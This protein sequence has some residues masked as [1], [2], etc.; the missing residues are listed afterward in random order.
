[1]DK[2]LATSLER[3]AVTGADPGNVLVKSPSEGQID[4]NKAFRNPNV[5]GIKGFPGLIAYNPDKY[6][7]RV[8]I[9][10]QTYKELVAL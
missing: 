4:F 3:L 1:M 6:G 2:T 5:G 9:K 8:H 7:K 10:K